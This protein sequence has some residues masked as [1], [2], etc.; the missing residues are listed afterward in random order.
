MKKS[1][2]VFS[3]ISILFIDLINAQTVKWEEIFDSLNPPIG[4]LVFDNDGSSNSFEFLT[5]VSFVDTN[6]VETG[7]VEPQAGQSFWFSNFEN[8]NFNGLIDEWIITPRIEGIESADS[9]S[10]YA[11]AIDQ[12]FDDSLRVFV[13][14]TDSLLTSFTNLIAYF[15]VDGPVGEYTKYSFDLS[16]FAGSDIF[17]AVNY[18]IV[19]GGV[20]GEHSD[21]LWIDH[22]VITN[23]AT[24]VG[25]EYTLPVNF[26]L[27][28][29]YP[30]P[31]NPATDIT[32][33]VPQQSEVTLNVYN[34]IGQLVATLLDKES[35]ARGRH[36]VQFDAANLPN[37]IYYY[38]IEAVNPSSGFTRGSGRFVDIKKMTLLK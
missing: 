29:N 28:Q 26:E 5:E 33:L 10:F 31:F 27:L 15:K 20:N 21:A 14:T 30:N 23:F 36:S 4:W 22:F 13:S 3:I 34:L 9:L 6:D 19:N 35:F 17:I 7:R 25:T 2:I 16:A 8:A 18:Y 11:G 1:A 38:K 12:G 24:S 32:F 37:G